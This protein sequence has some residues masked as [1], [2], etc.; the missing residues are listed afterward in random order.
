MNCLVRLFQQNIFK[1]ENLKVSR[2][3]LKKGNQELDR[4]HHYLNKA[5]AAFAEV[6]RLVPRTQNIVKMAIPQKSIYRF[7]AIPTK[8]SRQ[9]FTDHKRTVFS[10]IQKHK[11]KKQDSLT[12]LNS[13]RTV[14]QKY[15]QL[16]FQ[17]ALQSYGNNNSMALAQKKIQQSTESN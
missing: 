15:H 1:C 16:Q 9:F 5:H 7:S 14:C 10:F 11:K 17:V 2:S 13:K 6:L 12:I 8:I 4:Q 3:N